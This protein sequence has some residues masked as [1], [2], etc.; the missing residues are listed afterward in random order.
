MMAIQ[1]L[2]ISTSGTSILWSPK[3]STMLLTPVSTLLLQHTTFS[4]TIISL[5][6]S[7]CSLFSLMLAVITSLSLSLSSEHLFELFGEYGEINSVKVMW[8]RTDEERARKRNCGFVSFKRR[9]DAEEAKAALQDT[10]YEVGICYQSLTYLIIHLPTVPSLILKSHYHLFMYLL[11]VF[12]VPPS[13][14][15]PVITGLP[16]GIRMVQSR[17]NQL[18]TVCITRGKRTRNPTSE[19]SLRGSDESFCD[20]F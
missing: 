17:E 1:T 10:D 18:C 5:P 16:H 2:P 11:H 15:R 19:S 12:S 14:P 6:I 8:P 3:V 9:G 20:Q 7:H 13:V 4:Y